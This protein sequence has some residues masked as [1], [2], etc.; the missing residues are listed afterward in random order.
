MKKLLLLVC[1]AWSIG[2]KAE[3]I[4][5]NQLIMARHAIPTP[6][7][8]IEFLSALWSES[9]V[10]DLKKFIS[11]SHISVD[12][13]LLQMTAEGDKIY[14]RGLPD[15]IT[16]KPNG[17]LV[18]KNVEFV[19]DETLSF[20]KNQAAF[21]K[22]WGQF[23]PFANWKDVS[24]FL[25]FIPEAQAVGPVGNNRGVLVILTVAAFWPLL[26]YF[27]MKKTF[28]S[29]IAINPAA[30][31]KCSP[32]RYY[33]NGFRF[34]VNESLPSDPE[35]NVLALKESK[36][37][38]VALLF[39]DRK[40]NV[41]GQDGFKLQSKFGKSATVGGQSFDADTIEKTVEKT[42]SVCKENSQDK[43]NKDSI[44]IA[45]FFAKHPPTIEKLIDPDRTTFQSGRK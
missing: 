12:Q 33:Q 32:P 13:E 29:D 43:F 44:A 18:F 40:T 37:D 23:R 7:I 14:L 22:K 5:A 36:L 19:Y 8:A 21:E 4:S 6:K 42:I 31:I 35:I 41:S 16:V 28:T 27:K 3:P 25:L 34:Q 45:K 26:I 2:S 9:D 24:K 10:N 20:L 15:P 30:Q 38:G 11:S 17:T 1:V 39:F